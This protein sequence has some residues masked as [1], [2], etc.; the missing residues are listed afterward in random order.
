[1]SLSFSQDDIRRLLP[2]QL[3]AAGIDEGTRDWILHDLIPIS[4]REGLGDRPEFR[5]KVPLGRGPDGNPRTEQVR[6]F[7]C[8]NYDRDTRRCLAYATRSTACREFPWVETP[9]AGER[10]LLPAECA[11]RADL[12]LPVA[13]WQPVELHPR[14]V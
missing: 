3:E 4:Y 9:T 2:Y 6:F 14:K 8:R 11:F 13:E 10:Y 5:G 1:M 7:R 12:G